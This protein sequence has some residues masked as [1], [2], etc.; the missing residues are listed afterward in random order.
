VVDLS[1]G[2][3]DAGWLFV[4]GMQ[5][6]TQPYGA[7]TGTYADYYSDFAT[8]PMTGEDY[9]FVVLDPNQAGQD[10]GTVT[11][12]DGFLYDASPRRFMVEGYPASGPFAP[13]C[14]V[15]SCYV[16]YCYSRLFATYDD[17]DG[18]QFGIGCKS[19]H[20]ASGG[21]WFAK[22]QGQWYVA[23]VT[24]VGGAPRHPRRYFR[25]IWGAQFDDN[26]NS[27]F[28][29]AQQFEANPGQ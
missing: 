28:Q 21:P 12:T 8:L 11:G 14:S 4:P 24:S 15:D 9:A 23:S 18:S 29:D 13:D 6:N 19:G 10:V 17:L 5:G 1:S 7:W 16:W 2:L 22:Y 27:L 26:T 3:S 25:N 20:G